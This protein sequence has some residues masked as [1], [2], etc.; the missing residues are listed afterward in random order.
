[1]ADQCPHQ[2]T[3]PSF[4][5]EFDD[6]EVREILDSVA[7][8]LAGGRLTLGAM[9]A[10]FEQALADVC[11]TTY[12]I[13]VSSGS[14]ALEIIMRAVGVSSGVVL[15]PTNTNYATAAAALNAGARI[16]FYDGGLFFDMTDLERRLA[17]VPASAVVVVHI[18]GYL[19]PD[20]L[21]LAALCARY[22]VP[23]IE[24]AAHAHGATL[25]DRP[26]GSFGTAAAFS[27]FPT[28][29]ITTGEGGAITTSDHAIH[30]SALLLRDQGKDPDTGLHVVPGNSWRLGEMNAAVGM[31]QLRRLP[32]D[33]ARR[34]TILDAYH[35]GLAGTGL[36][37]EAGAPGSVPSGYKCIATPPA[38]VDRSSFQRRLLEHGVELGRGVYETPLHQQP[39]FRETLAARSQRFP[40][41]DR[42]ARH[43]VCLPIWRFMTETQQGHV[44]EAVAAVLSSER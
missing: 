44:I 32:I 41:A 20:I 40:I 34:K 2:V 18:G 27:F 9:T 3:V 4:R 38:H 8:A 39:V 31:A 21:E 29:L 37:V 6:D 12:A 28:K 30:A 23:L 17:R 13:A 36:S 22:G 10:T 35:A 7:R 24:D 19:A 33:R 5:V 1:M 26:A 11:G 14:S 25:H 43:H 15:L 16:E 42:F